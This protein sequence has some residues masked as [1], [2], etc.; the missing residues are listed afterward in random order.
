MKIRR[1]PRAAAAAVALTAVA[2]LAPVRDTRACGGFFARRAATTTTVT[3][4][5][6]QV[7]QVLILHDPAKEEE[8]FI[9][10]IVFRDAREPFGFVVPTPS[11]PTVAKVDRSP[12]AEL[13][14]RFPPEHEPAID[15]PG[16]GLGGVGA[17]GGGAPAP[18][19]KVISEERIGSFTAFVLAATDARAL[20]K[21][22]DA[23]ELATTP[24]SEAWLKHYVDLGFHFVA[25][26][27]ELP[28]AGA[29]RAR[30]K[31]EIVRISFSTPR[32]YYPYL[33]PEHPGAA[34]PGSRVLAVWVIAPE[35]GVPVAAVKDESGERL[36]KRPWKEARRHAP[37]TPASLG[38]ALGGSLAA[39]LPRPGA[40]ADGGAA[41]ERL[42]VQTF[43]DQKASRAGWGDV[44]LVPEAPVAIDA[45]RM[46]RLRRLMAALDDA[47]TVAP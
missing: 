4:P 28:D 20:E 36:W 25:F 34:A 8:H 33:E 15:A 31:S 43:Q 39:L 5:S 21:W 14:A 42:V 12:F 45:A 7:E 11:L 26:R 17:A 9:R 38:A 18:A 24:A 37:A 22:L 6:L 3:V 35:R 2:A 1:S 19:V 27:Y 32:P 30:T 47:V 40:E 41:G 44:V 10:E 46:K 23:N 29:P 16:R 13:A